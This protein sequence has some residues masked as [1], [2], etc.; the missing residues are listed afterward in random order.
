MVSRDGWKCR[1]NTHSLCLPNLSLDFIFAA[2]DVEAN[3]IVVK[4][5][6]Y[7]N[8]LSC[9]LFNSWV[10]LSRSERVLNITLQQMGDPVV[11]VLLVAVHAD[12]VHLDPAC[13]TQ[14]NLH[15]CHP[16]STNGHNLCHAMK[17]ILICVGGLGMLVASD[18]FTDKDYEAVDKVK[19]DL[20]M[21]AGA[22]LYGFSS[23]NLL[24]PLRR[25]TESVPSANA[26]EEFFV[27]RS[28]LYEVV[29]QL[30]MWGMLINGIQA[31]A[32]EYKGMRTA[33]WNS[34]IGESHPTPL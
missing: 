29:G 6:Q 23:F 4:A 5:Y 27:R 19:G 1:Q 22:T 33:T 28:P 21:F 26:A 25:R 20:F 16:V 12:Q 2:C 14:L 7:T 31:A 32:L 11:S 8:L 17:G 13:R 10:L 9:M 18:Q 3:F 34:S 30:G 24:G 15:L